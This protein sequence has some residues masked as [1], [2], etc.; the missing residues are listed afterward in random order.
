MKILN[1]FMYKKVKFM[2]YEQQIY[3]SILFMWWKIE[4]QTF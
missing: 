1:L 2:I 4:C 3:F